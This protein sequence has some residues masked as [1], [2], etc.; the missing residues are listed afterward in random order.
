MAAILAARKKTPGTPPHTVYRKEHARLVLEALHRCRIEILRSIGKSC[1]A[2]TSSINIDRMG[3]ALLSTLAS[4]SIGGVLLTSLAGAAPFLHAIPHSTL[5]QANPAEWPAR[6][7]SAIPT[8]RTELPQAIL[9]QGAIGTYR[10]VVTTFRDRGTNG[11]RRPC[12]DVSISP[13]PSPFGIATSD[14]TCRSLASIPNLMSA[15]IGEGPDEATVL[16]LAFQP[17]V[18]RVRLTLEHHGTQYISLRLLSIPAAVKAQV[19]RYRYAIRALPGP[20]CLRRFAAFD[21]YG[22]LASKSGLMGCSK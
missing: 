16:A 7:K 19:V 13:P 8:G 22:R 18:V 20:F 14:Q 17:S 11:S 3:R 5:R 15:S 9:G 10:W 2:A 1:R 21:R 4:I 12:I 6:S